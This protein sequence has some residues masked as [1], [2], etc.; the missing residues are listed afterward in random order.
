[1]TGARRVFAASSNKKPQLNGLKMRTLAGNTN[2]KNQ[3]RRAFRI[4]EIKPR[5]A[6][7][8]N[9]SEF[10]VLLKKPDKYPITVL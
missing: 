4:V 2:D 9:P 7:T 5:I 10:N 6:G 8:T 1:M 3:S